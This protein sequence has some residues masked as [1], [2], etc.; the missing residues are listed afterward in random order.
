[1]S[2]DDEATSKDKKPALFDSSSSDDEGGD[3]GD[4]SD[5]NRFAIKPQFEG[6]SGSK[7]HNYSCV[8]LYHKI[9]I[10][11]KLERKIVVKTL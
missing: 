2:Q 7:V 3:S 11:K 10:F 8:T 4:D 1:M 9:L 6:P 5:E